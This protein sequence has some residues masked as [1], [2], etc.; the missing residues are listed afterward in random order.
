MV[1]LCVGWLVISHDL[2]R[3]GGVVWLNTL[4]MEVLINQYADYL[5]DTSYFFDVLIKG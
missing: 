5:L 2:P 4:H 1:T 3:L